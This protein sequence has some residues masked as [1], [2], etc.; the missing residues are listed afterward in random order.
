MSA[1]ARG[2]LS[3]EE[4]GTQQKADWEMKIHR[5]YALNE[6]IVEKIALYLDRIY[7][8]LCPVQFL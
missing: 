5:K 6:A 1:H 8:Y 4:E 2:D 7:W 3:K